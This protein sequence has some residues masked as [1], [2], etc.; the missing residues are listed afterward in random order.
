MKPAVYGIPNCDSVKKAR[1]WLN[2]HHIDHEFVD[3]RKN[4][5]SA[6]QL[7]AWLEA[8]GDRVLVNRRSTSW[9]NLPVADREGIDAGQVIPVLAANPTLI[10]RPVLACGADI[11]VG[12]DAASY[13]QRFTS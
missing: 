6:E 1:R 5:P 13:S 7:R 9:K 11:T 10:K 4:P 8:V 3:L 12:F 2:D